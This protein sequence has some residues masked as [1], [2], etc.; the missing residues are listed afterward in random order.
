MINKDDSILLTG[1][2]GFLGSHVLDEL[3]R[4]GYTNVTGINS[5]GVNLVSQEATKEFFRKYR[6]KHIIGCHGRTGGIGANSLYPATF[7]Y[8]N[9]MMT[10]NLLNENSDLK[11]K[12]IIIG[13]TCSYPAE[14]TTP[15]KEECL[16]AGGLPE[17]SNQAYALAKIMGLVQLQAMNKQFGLK[18]NYLL[19]A[20]LL[21]PRDT[22]DRTRSHAIPAII[23]KVGDAMRNREKEIVL[24]GTGTATREFL[25]VRECARGIVLSLEK[26][27]SLEP[28]NLGTGQEHSI[29]SITQMICDDMGFEGEIKLDPSKPDGQKR[30]CL[31]V[32]RAKQEFGF[33]SSY[34]LI[35]SIQDTVD[36]YLR[37]GRYLCN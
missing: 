17:I 30:R 28:C 36:Y 20:N 27:K 37:E 15:F 4:Q 12:A 31:D 3:K 10:T 19:P 5:K 23:S 2:T 33:E 1:Y 14:A 9:L 8:D 13:T 24:W 34:P 22:F 32:S 29:L 7:F 18:Y 21:G 11:G 6:F 26:N 16:L 25:D 35:R